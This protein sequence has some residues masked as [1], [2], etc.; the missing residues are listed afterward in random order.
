ML[1]IEGFLKHVEQTDTCWL[2]TGCKSK[3]GY[4]SVTINRVT[5]RAHRVSY[6]L[7]IG[8]IPIGY[9][10]CHKCDNPSCVNP[11]HLFPGTQKDNVQDSIK[12]GRFVTKNSILY[13]KG[14]LHGN[15]KLTEERVR[16]ILNEF[17]KKQTSSKEFCETF[18]K[19]FGLKPRT[20]ENII[21]RLSWKHVT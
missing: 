2:W 16:I 7:F 3:R 20:L 17:K 5:K 14:S 6:E 10:I 1:T 11:E 18:S 12:K 8:T 13:K 4:G 15:A 9:G 21:Y 19:I